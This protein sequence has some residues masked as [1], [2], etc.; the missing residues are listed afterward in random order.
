MPCYK[1]IDVI[2][3]PPNKTEPDEGYPQIR[4]PYEVPIREDT[5]KWGVV[6]NLEKVG[7]LEYLLYKLRNP[8]SEKYHRGGGTVVE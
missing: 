5:R 1:R 4:K 6:F 7:F 2:I 8:F 3:L